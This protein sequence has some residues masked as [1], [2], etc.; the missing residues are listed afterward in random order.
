MFDSSGVSID[1]QVR[2]VFETNR[3]ASHTKGTRGEAGL[4]IPS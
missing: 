2:F 1:E 4:Q 3:N